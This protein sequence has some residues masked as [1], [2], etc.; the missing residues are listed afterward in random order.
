[1]CLLQVTSTDPP[2]TEPTPV[3]NGTSSTPAISKP[4]QE[5][6]LTPTPPQPQTQ[7]QTQT[8]APKTSSQSQET[9]KRN[10]SPKVPM[11]Q[12]AAGF[13]H[14]PQPPRPK[15][16]TIGEDKIHTAGFLETVSQERNTRKYISV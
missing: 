12:T 11:T 5:C 13:P 1:M 10:F 16:F 6:P 7:T 2:E 4:E 9:P 15:A 3:L 14:S 8:Q